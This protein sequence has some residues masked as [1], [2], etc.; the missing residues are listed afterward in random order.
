MK[1]LPELLNQ[2]KQLG[3]IKV[4]AHKNDGTPQ[5][6]GNAETDRAAEHVAKV[7][8]LGNTFV[9]TVM[10]ECEDEIRPISL[11]EWAVP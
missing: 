3:L 1:E 6:R 2:P 8:S 7:E 10:D 11:R 5:A 9:V 4:A